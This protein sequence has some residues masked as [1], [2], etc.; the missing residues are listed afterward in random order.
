MFDLIV[1]G[2]TL[3]DGR[4]ADIGIRG[5]RIIEVGRIDAE[6]GRVID[7]T[8]DLVSPPFVDPHFHMDAVLSYGLPRVNASG[9]L[10]EGIGLWGELRA[11]AT[12][13]DMVARALRYCDWA[14]SMGLLAIRTHVDTTP[15][16][17]RGVEAMLE[18]K[19]A[20]APYLDL[21]LVAFPQD[22]FYRSATGRQ[23]LL[24]ALDMGV[25]VVGGIP[26]FERTMEEG[27]E[28]LR[29]LGRIAAERGLMWDVHCDETD[30]PQSRHVETLAREV[31]RHGLGARAAGSHLS[32]MHSMDNYY[33]SKLIPL[34]AES[35]MTAIPNPLINITL[36]GRHD[37]YPK[38]R[39]LT[40]VKELQAAGVTVGWGQDCVLDPW[41]SLGTADMLD[42][43]F[44]GLHVAQMTHP[45]E[46]AR[47][48][49]MVTQ[50]NA[51]IM[52][53]AGYGLRP[54]AVASLVVL[55]AGDP[56]EAL[57]LR[58]DRLAV[59]SK[60]RIVAQKARND[61]QLSLPGR[62]DTVRR[63]H[64]TLPWSL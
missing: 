16:H 53:L 8:G 62:A 29:D 57:R 34:I 36:Q 64:K 42:V 20:V 55:D 43:A 24:R 19:R 30:D 5:D 40:R 39:G 45:D 41:Y 52:G 48:F 60:G 51:T 21:Q 35:G 11:V 13:E 37:S 26:H 28:S 59:V 2:G 50:E 18:V 15:D 7:A 44:M 58:P 25:D 6:A 63:R 17:L 22:G 47:C 61:T 32:S 4:V 33:V 10:L 31:T 49:H 27:A 12:V 9:T 3:P 54:G 1:R 38:R 56:V 46:M 14:V 23:N